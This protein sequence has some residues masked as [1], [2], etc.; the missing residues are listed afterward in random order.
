MDSED[1]VIQWARSKKKGLVKS[2]LGKHKYISSETPKIIFMAGLPGAGKTEFANKLLPQ[3]EPRMLQ[4]DMDELAEQIQEYRP[5]KAHLFRAGATIILE[6]LF[7]KALDRKIDI[8]L[9]GTFGHPKA[10]QNVERAIERH[11][12][13]ARVYLILQDPQYAWEKT[14]Y[15]EILQHRA[16]DLGRFCDTYFYILENI[17]KLQVKY[18]EKVPI[19]VVLKN[20]DNSLKDIIQNVVDVRKYTVPIIERD[21]LEDVLSNHKHEN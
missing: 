16:I 15:R 12:Y 1:K 9:D 20:K 5:K 4:I 17:N 7:D 3:L 13:I 8:L 2:I 19:T 21:K 14:Q 10:L 18:G 11:H 6:F